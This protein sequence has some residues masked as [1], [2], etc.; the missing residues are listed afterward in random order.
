M[1]LS[2][3]GVKFQMKPSILK[4]NKKIRAIV[5]TAFWFIIWQVI[6]TKVGKDILIPSPLHTLQTLLYMIG[7]ENLYLDIGATVYRVIVGI[8]ISFFIGLITAVGAYFNIMLRDIL[9]PLIIALKTTPV[10]AIIIVA[11]L[12]FTSNNVPI[13]VCFFMC[14]PIV[15]TNILTGLDNMDRQLLEVASIYQVK[16]KYIVMDLYIPH[17]KPYIKSALS[18]IIGLAWKVI[19]AAEVLA[20]PKYSMGYNLLN[21]KVYL[22]TERLFSWVII[23]ICLSSLCEK[24]VDKYILNREKVKCDRG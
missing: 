18:L 12:W 15:Y 11:L 6:Y 19:V 13:L 8:S 10:M 17:I 9:K 14:Y 23:I 4:S 16:K 1:N 22:E 3:L 20:V 5:V 7:E 2:L 21:A 24:L